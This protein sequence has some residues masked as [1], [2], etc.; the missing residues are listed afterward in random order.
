MQQVKW[1]RDK[2]TNR[3]NIKGNTG[4]LAVERREKG[5]KHIQQVARERVSRLST[6]THPGNHRKIGEERRKQS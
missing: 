6:K 5:G 3:Y 1:T 2:R 4:S